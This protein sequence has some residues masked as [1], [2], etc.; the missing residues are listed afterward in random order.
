MS[1]AE[2]K[3]EALRRYNFVSGSSNTVKQSGQDDKISDRVD[4]G[5]KKGEEKSGVSVTIKVPDSIEIQEGSSRDN[6]IDRKKLDPNSSF[7]PA[8]DSESSCQKNI[9][10]RFNRSSVRSSKNR[11]TTRMLIVIV[12]VFLVV[13]LPGSFLHNLI[14]L[15]SVH[16][17]LESMLAENDDVFANINK[18]IR[19]SDSLMVIVSNS[20]NFPIIYLMSTE[21]RQVFYD[22]FGIEFICSKFSLIKASLSRMVP[23]CGQQQSGNQAL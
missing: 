17:G 5:E 4:N 14:V 13:E 8:L 6:N 10:K 16:E 22:T 3:R 20:L 15:I 12:S 1:Q 11:R 23:F 18:I 9:T 7:S 21:F 19:S 2:K